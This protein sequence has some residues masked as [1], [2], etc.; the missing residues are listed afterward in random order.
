MTGYGWSERALVHGAATWRQGR[1]QA[2]TC[3]SAPD[4][5][6]FERVVPH[7]S[8]RLNTARAAHHV[9]VT[10][11]SVLGT[12]LQIITAREERTSIA[13][14]TNLPFSEGGT[15]LPDPRPVPPSS[16]ASPAM[17]TPENRHPVL[18]A[19]HPQDH[20]PAPPRQLRSPNRAGE[21]EQKPPTGSS[22]RRASMLAA[23]ITAIAW[24]HAH[25]RAE[26]IAGE[27]VDPP[28]HAPLGVGD[29]VTH[30]RLRS[31]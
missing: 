24:H 28:V 16:T 9:A 23:T 19:T 18:P 29:R 2:A 5:G 31:G 30:R 26:D 4:V 10:I 12:S 1:I 3:P 27:S 7:T 14:A 11:E 25:T 6:G 20:G 15:V 17:A 22:S 8:A 13:D 21:A